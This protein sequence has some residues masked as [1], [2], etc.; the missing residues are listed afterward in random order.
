MMSY[1]GS[2]ETRKVVGKIPY[3]DRIG[4]TNFLES[5]SREGF[6]PSAS[7]LLAGKITN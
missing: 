2:V 6:E 1:P 3:P 7:G 5:E 4:L